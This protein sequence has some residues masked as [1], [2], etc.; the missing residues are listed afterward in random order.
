MV[1]FL[2]LMHNLICTTHLEPVEYSLQGRE[3]NEKLDLS[4]DNQF[5]TLLK[6]FGAYVR[7]GGTTVV[8][9]IL[10]HLAVSCR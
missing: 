4:I 5:R 6:E 3:V 1:H 8:R 10:K 2:A 9:M 7:E